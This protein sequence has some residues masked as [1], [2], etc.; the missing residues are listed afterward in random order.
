MEKFRYNSKH[1]GPCSTYNLFFP[2]YETDRRREKW[3]HI[4]AYHVQKETSFWRFLYILV[5]I[6]N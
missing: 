3:T 6:L 1:K 5:E 2:S 4:K